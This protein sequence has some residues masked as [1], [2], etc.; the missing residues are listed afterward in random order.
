[1][2]QFDSCGSFGSSLNDSFYDNVYDNLPDNL[3]GYLSYFCD[4]FEHFDNSDLQNED[5]RFYQDVPHRNSRTE[6]SRRNLSVHCSLSEP[7]VIFED[8]VYKSRITEFLASI[9]KPILEKSKYISLNELFK[10]DFVTTRNRYK[11]TD[12]TG[13]KK[14]FGTHH[15]VDVEVGTDFSENGFSLV[16]RKEKNNDSDRRF[17][18]NSACF[19]YGFDSEDYKN[20]MVIFRENCHLGNTYNCHISD[21]RPFDAKGYHKETKIV[22]IFYEKLIP[23]S[24]NCRDDLYV[25]HVI[26]MFIDIP[27]KNTSGYLYNPH[28]SKNEKRYRKKHL[29][30]KEYRYRNHCEKFVKI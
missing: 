7:E 3:F 15:N 14:G 5:E 30:Q 6:K 23:V 16:S 9:G 19:C 11:W 29:R 2:F 22:H 8:E 17:N 10:K 18:N 27:K 28:M 25:R 12:E 13:K 24:E 26:K 1:M 21:W 4:Y 20:L